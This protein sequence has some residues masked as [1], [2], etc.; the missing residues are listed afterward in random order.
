MAITLRTEKGSPLTYEE[1]DGN[2]T[3]L[4]TRIST[5]EGAEVL[6]VNG[7]SGV[8]VLT[9][10]NIAEGSNLYYT[11]ARFDNDFSDQTTDL[12]AEGI[13][14]VYFTNTRARSSI[15]VGTGLTYNST[16]GVISLSASTTNITEGTNLFFTNARADAR[17]A[18]ANADDL[19]DVEY[20]SPP[21][22]GDVLTWNTLTGTWEPAQ[23][24]GATGGEANTASNVG[25]GQGIFAVKVAQDLRFYTIAGSNG[26]G[27]SSPVSN[28]I[29]ISNTQDISTSANTVF[30]TVRGGNLQLTNNALTSTD[31]NGNINLTPN[32]TG[33]VI[34]DTSTVS[35]TGILY[36]GASK[37]V[38]TNTNLTFTGTTLTVTG[39]AN[40]TNNINSSNTI[41]ASRLISNIATGTAPFI[42]TSTTQVA[43]LNV[44]TAGTAATVTTAAQP[45][46]TSVGTL[47]S[48]NVSGA[49]QSNFG[50]SLVYATSNNFSSG[51]SVYKR[52]TTGDATAAVVS[53][54]ELG[55]HN[56]FGWDGTDYGRG[57]YAIARATENWNS[58]SRGTSYAI[59]T[60]ANGSTTNTVRLTVDHD[61]NVSIP[62]SATVSNLRITNANIESTVTNSNIHILPNGT[63]N[64]GIKKT[65]PTSALDVNGTIT[66]TGLSV[67]GNLTL[68]GASSDTINLLGRFSSALLPSSTSAIDLGSSSNKFRTIFLSGNLNVD[69]TTTLSASGVNS[70]IL[71]ATNNTFDLGSDAVRWKD[72][73][74]QGDINFA[75]GD[76]ITTAATTNLVNTNATTLNFAGAATTLIAGATTGSAIHRNPTHIFGAADTSATPTASTIRA[77]D[78]S[79]TD[80]AGANLSIR[81]GRSTGSGAGGTLIFQ[82]ANAGIT[83]SSLNSAITRMAIDTAVNVTANI[84]PTANITY[85][86][87]STSLRF[88]N[89]WG[90]S[91]SAQYADLAERYEADAVYDVGTVVVF[92]GEKEIT[93]TSIQGD[94][95]VAGVVSENPAYIMND[96]S[97]SNLFPPIALRGK[98]KVKC[99]GKVSKGD[100]LITSE[101][102]SYAIS[103]QKNDLGNAVFAKAISDKT[104]EQEYVW[105]VII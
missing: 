65:N 36:A 87:G 2:F 55:Y 26:I 96:T 78:A 16:T 15:S 51:L 52:G 24:P 62:G 77:T 37:E 43:N 50:F 59:A 82:T 44:A 57:A 33:N 10:S 95:S 71:P 103:V 92:G 61:G 70:N 20:T 49:I 3:D 105:A 32:G 38:L 74:A 66:S 23:P 45:N 101:V 14:N 98:V 18:L 89:I 83:G 76:L 88:A 22:A 99:I 56:F 34:V 12:L 5:L 73:F 100:L 31:T 46:I 7:Q 9:T 58:T 84:L 11:S 6:S 81:A 86:L 30:L 8:V 42:V 90:L 67:A 94:V 13:T 63:G 104:E 47:S 48:L 40:V 93:I 53:T 35:A 54:A 97:D 17:I 1:L 41:T 60:T 80:I 64:V 29:T 79:G 28:V 4:D 91:S 68:G 75:G 102:P 69:G 21:I 27:I 25:L 39:N 85:N 19:A 72:I